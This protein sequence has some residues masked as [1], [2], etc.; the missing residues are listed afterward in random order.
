MEENEIGRVVKYFTH[1]EAAVVELSDELKV[2]DTIAIRGH[3]TKLEQKVES[4]QVGQDIIEV[5]KKG[6]AVGIKVEERVRPHDAVYKL[7][8]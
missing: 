4:M 5:A 7:I 6:D 3:T 1:V 2:G 8:S